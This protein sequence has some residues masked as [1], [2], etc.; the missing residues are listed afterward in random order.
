MVFVETISVSGWAQRVC[1]CVCVCVYWQDIAVFGKC[2]PVLFNLWII[3]GQRG[4]GFAKKRFGAVSSKSVFLIFFMDFHFFFTSPSALY[5]NSWKSPSSTFNFVFLC[6]CKCVFSNAFFQFVP[7]CVSGLLNHRWRA[8]KVFPSGS[9]CSSLCSFFRAMGVHDSTLPEAV[10]G[11]L[12]RRKM[13]R[14]GEMQSMFMKGQKSAEEIGRMQL[15]VLLVKIMRGR[16]DQ[17]WRQGGRVRRRRRRRGKDGRENE[18]RR[19]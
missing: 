18:G 19:W 15:G 17:E 13:V 11:C 7:A 6:V 2:L 1:V 4:R 8:D 9:R 14:D 12:P 5:L 3:A 10:I 16:G